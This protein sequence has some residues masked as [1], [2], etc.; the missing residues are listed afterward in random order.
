MGA[1]RVPRIDPLPWSEP[2]PPE[3]QTVVPFT[4]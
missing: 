2:V 3:L 1:E 4:G